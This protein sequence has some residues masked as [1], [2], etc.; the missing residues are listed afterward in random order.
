[1]K[2]RSVKIENCLGIKQAELDFAKVNIVLGGNAQCKSSLA[3]ALSLPFLGCCPIRGVDKKKDRG[4]MAHDGHKMSVQVDTDLGVYSATASSCGKSPLDDAVARI[5]FNPQAVLTMTAKE[6]QSIFGSVFKHASA[7]DKI[8][9][10]LSANNGWNPEVFDRCRGDLDQAQ[11]WAVEERRTA[12]RVKAEIEE[13][14]K[15]G[16]DSVTDHEGSQIDFTK[17][18]VDQIADRQ[19][20]RTAERD[21]LV[22]SLGE[23]FGTDGLPEFIEA[24][25]KDLADISDEKLNSDLK[26][27]RIKSA[28]C[29]SGF[30]AAETKA[31]ESRAKF[32]YAEKQ[33][34][35]ME[36][37]GKK[38]PTCSRELTEIVRDDIIHTLKKEENRLKVFLEKAA[39]LVRTKQSTWT[40]ASEVVKGINKQIR[41]VKSARTS[42]ETQIE[43][44]E[45]VL[46]RE[47][48]RPKLEADIAE[49]DKRLINIE[50][51]KGKKI[52]Y[53][54]YALTMTDAEQKIS[55]AEQ[56]ID[57]MNR[58][59]AL[60]KPDGELRIISN[61][62]I[63]SQAMFDKILATAWDMESLNLAA[64]GTV[65]YK[66]RPIEMASASERYRASV[67][68]AELLGRTVDAGVLVLDGLDIL[69][70]NLRAKVNGRLPAWIQNFETILMICTAEKPEKIPNTSWLRFFWAED[71]TI[72]NLSDSYTTGSN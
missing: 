8:E 61:Q 29:E 25:K 63:E 27:A 59:D 41:E 24:A 33:R 56:T 14:R 42:L 43:D 69:E 19:R 28:Q 55:D 1:M 18:S 51:I 66:D 35:A 39:E 7:S 50:Q 4:L 49:L 15:H 32:E 64:D 20:Q 44:T 48:K 40:E 6:R 23:P 65:S 17:I 60:L 13:L 22:Q 26:E 72:E 52:A 54:E 10:Y 12:K 31:S 62:S 70:P 11:E 47:K 34:T 57:E 2:I 46:E 45:K 58:L 36:T 67:L 16:V 3:N 37:I 68:L 9:E 38:C 71:G 53:D 5:L 21:A 30:K